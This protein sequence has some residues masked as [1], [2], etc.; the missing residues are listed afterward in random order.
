MKN[1]RAQTTIEIA[2]LIMLV[3]AAL[4]AMRVYIKRAFQGAYRQT[5]DSVGEQYDPRATTSS[6]TYSHTGTTVTLSDSVQEGGET[7]STSV[8]VMDESTDRT[9]TETLE[10]MGGLWD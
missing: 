9:G 5:A 4:L 1:K 3:V 2:L 8:S 6:I 10:A 7:N